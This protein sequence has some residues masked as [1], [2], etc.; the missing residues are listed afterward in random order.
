MITE[1]QAV[2]T[3]PSTIIIGGSRGH[4]RGP[5]GRAW[6]HNSLGLPYQ[7]ATIQLYNAVIIVHSQRVPCFHARETDLQLLDATLALVPPS[8]LTYVL[9]QRPAGIRVSDSTGRGS[10]LSY[11]GGSNPVLGFDD[12]ATTDFIEENGI[13]IT[14][15]A[16]LNFAHLGICPTI[17]HEFGHRMLHE[18]KLSGRFSVTEREAMI[19]ASH[20]RSASGDLTEAL[21]DAYMYM[22]CY[23][24][25]DRNIQAFGN[26]SSEITRCRATRT[27]LRR[28]EAF[29][30]M[31]REDGWFERYAER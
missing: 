25:S 12:P 27:V 9:S 5:D 23:G 11:T 17:F 8:H 13:L 15:G 16:F 28:C 1:R 30:S 14:F 19:T 10:N 22:L 3:G 24:A 26:R 29:N 20:S 18:N 6:L 31:V 7:N 4:S 2:G 21:C